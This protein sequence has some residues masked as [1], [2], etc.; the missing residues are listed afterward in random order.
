MT[1]TGG[2]IYKKRK[3][4]GWSMETLGRKT[5]LSSRTID[6]VEKGKAKPHP[7]TIMS[8]EQAFER[9]AGGE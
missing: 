6:S 9:E 4:L 3:D 8:I 1:M 5:G 7:V 2:E